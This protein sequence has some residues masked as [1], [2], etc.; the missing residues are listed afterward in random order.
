[1]VPSF[2]APSCW[3]LL[4][5]GLP[6]PCSQAGHVKNGGSRLWACG[7]SSQEAGVVR[8]R[9]LG[10]SGLWNSFAVALREAPTSFCLFLH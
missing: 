8:V 10:P 4:L 6:H 3:A 2:E 7:P 5:P 9:L 1:M